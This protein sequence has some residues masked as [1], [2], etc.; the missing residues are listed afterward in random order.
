MKLVSKGISN[1]KFVRTKHKSLLLTKLKFPTLMQLMSANSKL[2]W[3][4]LTEMMFAESLR[5]VLATV[6]VIKLKKLDYVKWSKRFADTS[7]S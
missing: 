2:A 3:T 4:R 7:A 1:V 5:R 6:N